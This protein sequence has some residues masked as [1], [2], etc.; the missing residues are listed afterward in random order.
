[1]ITADHGFLYQRDRLENSQKLSVKP[2]E[3][4][5][6]SRRFAVLD[7]QENVDGTLTYGLDYLSGQEGTKVV[8]VPKGINRFAVQGP[9]TNYVHGGAML[10]EIVVPVITVKKERRSTLENTVSSVDVKLTTPMRKI[11]N[12]V[13]YLE[14]SKQK[15]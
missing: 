1:M 7:K 5:E 12:A 2:E 3:T 14:F 13:I 4:I 9:G 15:R 11:T 8:M 10:Q 6:M